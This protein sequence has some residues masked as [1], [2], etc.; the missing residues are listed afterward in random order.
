MNKRSGNHQKPYQEGVESRTHS[1]APTLQLLLSAKLLL[2]VQETA[3]LLGVSKR[4]IFLLLSSGE[5]KRQKVRRRTM[6]HRDDVLRFAAGV[7]SSAG[8]SE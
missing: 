8:E 6:I 4:T 3:D 1:E 5:L 7:K 2:S